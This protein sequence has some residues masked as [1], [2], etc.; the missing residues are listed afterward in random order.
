MTEQVIALTSIEVCFGKIRIEL[1]R[2]TKVRLGFLKHG[3]TS[4]AATSHK[5][6]IRVGIEAIKLNYFIKVYESF[7]KIMEVEQKCASKHQ[8]TFIGRIIVD[9]VACKNHNL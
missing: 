8:E 6:R 7:V 1:N 5:V 3:E 2:A 9:A 4:V